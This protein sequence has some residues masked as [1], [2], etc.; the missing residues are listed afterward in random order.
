MAIKGRALIQLFNKDT[1]EEI[2]RQESDNI[3]CN[4]YKR[5]I[6]PNIFLDGNIPGNSKV[7]LGSMTPLWQKMFK[8]ILLF[9]EKIEPQDPDNFMI[10]KDMYGSFVGNASSS[11]NGNSIFRGSFNANESG[12]ISDKEVKLVFDFNSSA[13][14]SSKISAIALCPAFLGDAGLIKDDLD[15]SN[16][17]LINTYGRDFAIS[18]LI[19]KNGG[20]MHYF[21][22]H[23]INTYGYYLYSKDYQTNVYVKKDNKKYI[24]TE[25]TKKVDL[26]LLDDYYTTSANIEDLNLYTSNTFEVDYE[27]ETSIQDARYLEY[28]QGF[29][30][31][32]NYT[33]TQGNI[34]LKVYKINAETYEKVEVKEYSFTIQDLGNAALYA[35]VLFNNVYFT[36][37]NNRYLYKFDLYNGSFKSIEIPDTTNYYEVVK[38]YDTIMLV[39]RNK[40][41]IRMPIFILDSNDNLCKNYL[42]FS[43]SDSDYVS[44]NR[45]HTNNDCINYPL[46]NSSSSAYS[47]STNLIEYEN[48]IVL[49]HLSS[50]NNLQE[51]IQKNNSNTMKI[52]YIIKMV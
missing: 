51:S 5:L 40:H 21:N 18:P 46:A 24:F 22:R 52:T 19:A 43:S 9:S 26:G 25:T 14:N 42:Y 7:G 28:S 29:I 36:T 31:F 30:Y 48:Q 17:T 39:T 4:N 34:T 13:A 41:D 44:F 27:E 38:L 15:T 2:Y 10:T 1:N 11:W 20:G 3:I 35:R 49:P 50:I 12:P 33:N 47:T 23:K 16:T 6:Q 45:I 37:S 8:G 32:V